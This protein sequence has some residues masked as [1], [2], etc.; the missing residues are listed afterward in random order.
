MKLNE[1]LN[2]LIELRFIHENLNIMVVL[3]NGKDDNAVNKLFEC[4]LP[5][6]Q[7]MHF[8]GEFEVIR[9]QI[10]NIN[11]QPVFWFMLAYKEL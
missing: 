7:A 8:F 5:V 10:K 3:N 2:S 6:P 1:V 4:Y 11:N 9:N